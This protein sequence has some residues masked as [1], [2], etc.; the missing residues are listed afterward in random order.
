MLNAMCLDCKKLNND[1][2][3]TEC[4]TWTG[5]IYK[6]RD[7]NICMKSIPCCGCAKHETCTKKKN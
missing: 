2:N 3:G 4:Q 7:E 6:E 5:C 1:C